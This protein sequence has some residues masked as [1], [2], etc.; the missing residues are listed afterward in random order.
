MNNAAKNAATLPPLPHLTLRVG[1]AGNRTIAAALVPAV[2]ARL[3]EVVA[4]ITARLAAAVAS[5]A[6]RVTR[7]YCDQRPPLLRLVTGLAEGADAL[8]VDAVERYAN[9]AATENTVATETAAVLPFDVHTYRASRDPAFLPVFD[10]QAA[11]CSYILALDGIYEKPSPDTPL[12]QQ[13]RKRAYRAQAAF[14]LRHCD[15]LVV[16]ADPGREGQAGGAIETL[17]AA[18]AFGLPVIFIDVTTA[19]VRLIA[20]EDDLL[21][22]L[23]ADCA[24]GSALAD[25]QDQLIRVVDE[26]IIGPDV[27][28][29]TD[30]DAAP[31]PANRF[32]L[33]DEYFHKSS[34]PP[35][36]R[37]P[38]GTLRRVK[39]MRERLWARLD[40]WLRSAGDVGRQPMRHPPLAAYAKWRNRATELNYD[41][42]GLYR[43]AFLAN[44][45]LAVAAVFFAALSLAMIGYAPGATHLEQLTLV[46]LVF[47]AIKLGIVG[48]IFRNT[49][50]ARHAS[51]NERAIDYRYLAERLRAL[52]FLPG[53]GSFQ[54]PY[55]APPEYASRVECQSMVDWLADAITRSISAVEALPMQT[56]HVHPAD[57]APYTVAVARVDAHGA[58]D[59]ARTGWVAEQIVYHDNNAKAMQHLHGVLELWGSRLTKAVIAIVVLDIALLGWEAG[60][61]PH[62]TPVAVVPH[63]IAVIL[64]LF[65]AVLPA[66]VA[67]LNGI[68]FQS[69][70]R[71]LF[72]RSAMM[73]RRLKGRVLALE[74]LA[75]KIL[76][77]RADSSADE[78]AWSAELLRLTETIARDLVA[79]VGEWS[80]LYTREVP[81]PG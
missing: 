39:S 47:A 60:F 77:A 46:L 1:V 81:D 2:A 37:N 40:D 57:A 30:D 71:R 76:E 52:N 26:I 70:C 45:V 6:G 51:W 5:R 44:Y 53:I 65:A 10:R 20:P 75:T 59:A 17:R 32:A 56:E 73:H 58:A 3:D 42:A 55:V 19:T 78:G 18:L 29:A 74:Q 54:P 80:V 8:G 66:A 28:P 72:E 12:A 31:D 49:H 35:M 67:S 38:Q 64:L 79:E 23:D 50:Q 4:A 43:G 22:A 68:R 14:L 48:T 21:A 63:T 7:F 27:R 16:A 11:R 69:E 13:R 15:L 24:A 36:E 25:W 62:G 41:A 34:V 61:H 9:A 33:L